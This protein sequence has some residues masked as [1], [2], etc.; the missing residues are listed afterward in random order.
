MDSSTLTSTSSRLL[1]ALEKLGASKGAGLQSPDG[2]GAQPSQDLVRAFEE[3]LAGNP[4][5]ETQ[6][7]QVLQLSTGDDSLR[8]QSAG[9]TR[10]EFVQPADSA[11]PPDGLSPLADKVPASLE[12]LPSQGPRSATHGLHGIAETDAPQ[13]GLHATENPELHTAPG[14]SGTAQG[15]M[16]ELMG[17]LDK[18]SNGQLSASELYRLQYLVGMLKVQA[19]GGTQSAQQTSQGIESLLKQQG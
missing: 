3:A 1:E 13:P 19:T 15:D 10:Y 9:E 17:I 18:I 11:M 12:T 2:P 5:P 7:P 8:P 14:V 4:S 6:D 16:Q